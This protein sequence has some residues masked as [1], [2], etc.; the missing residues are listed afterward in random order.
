L[1]E[2]NC[3]G[4]VLEDLVQ[5]REL[6]GSAVRLF[7][8]A[9]NR[10]LA[11]G[12]AGTAADLL[13][14]AYDLLTMD[15]FRVE[16]TSLA[17]VLA[18]RLTALLRAG[19]GADAHR[20]TGQVEQLDWAGLAPDRLAVLRTRLA[21]TATVTGHRHEGTAQVAAV[22][23]LCGAA[24]GAG[25]AP[26]DAVA[27]R[28]AIESVGDSAD[29]D[30]AAAELGRRALAAALREDL[31]EAACQAL[32]V[33]GIL[34]RRHETGG[35]TAYFE[36]MVEHA[37][38]HRLPYWSLLAALHLGIE[39]WLADGTTVRLEQVARAATQLDASAI[40][41]SATTVLALDL[42]LTGRYPKAGE[43]A[44][45][46]HAEAAA[47]GLGETVRSL[48][49]VR[50]VLA[51][52][53]GRRDQLTVALRE[54]RELGGDDSR[55]A[56]LATGLAGAW[57]ALLEEDRPRAVAELDRVAARQPGPC[58]VAGPQGLR[59]LLAALDGQD[60]PPDAPPVT[61]AHWNRQ[62][63]LLARA[64]RLGRAGHGERAG[65]VA[66]E[67]GRVAARYPMA[68]HLG[69]RLVAEAAYRD[70]WGRP[71]DWL[72][73][74]EAYFHA[75][76]VPAVAVAARSLLRRFGA[77]LPQRREGTEDVPSALRRLGVTVREH[78]V[79][80]LLV[81][82]SGNRAI[83]Q[84]L[85]ISHRTVEKHVASLLMKLGQTNRDALT[86]R[87]TALLDRPTRGSGMRSVG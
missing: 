56:P 55:L 70:D 35:S 80:G 65:Q 13:G 58:P 74:A 52:H 39:D 62:F 17:D 51:G 8:N 32:E 4:D 19:R 59:V 87:A 86:D 78:E 61:G 50:A 83:A 21:Q 25:A 6:L 31:P 27:A 7:V 16:D 63:L 38:A 5:A 12:R 54:F 10:S 46:C 72:R 1:S 60:R 42:V 85:H 57:C 45:R 53:Q 66:E 23:A 73:E 24:N 3:T 43:L 69:L 44:A 47:L 75:S 84:R 29:S 15:D 71:A 49:V 9:G 14:R 30:D 33:L 77:P 37:R 28:L 18:A 64:V 68:R 81:T 22:R 26:I 36:R 40:R 41:C 20:L 34:A 82:R 67:A 11:A 79:L 2:Q 48:A 76:S